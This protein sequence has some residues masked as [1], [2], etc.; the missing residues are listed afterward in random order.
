MGISI[1]AI[2]ES[3]FPYKVKKYGYMDT[4]TD[5]VFIT[6]FSKDSLVE[7]LNE[8]NEL[9]IDP[10]TLPYDVLVRELKRWNRALL[11]E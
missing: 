10:R 2:C 8:C 11:E 1:V 5:T 9:G 7:Y 3:E 4:T 6:W